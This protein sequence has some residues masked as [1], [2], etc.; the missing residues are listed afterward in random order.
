M[1]DQ[2]RAGEEG[3]DDGAPLREEGPLAAAEQDQLLALLGK[4]VAGH[5]AA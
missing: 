1:L 3:A 4:L 2:R 5:E